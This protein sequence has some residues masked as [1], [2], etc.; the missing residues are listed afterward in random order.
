[1]LTLADDPE[2]NLLECANRIEVIDAR[3]ARHG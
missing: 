3:K 1:M 2:A